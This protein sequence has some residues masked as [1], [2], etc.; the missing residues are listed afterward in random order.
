MDGPKEVMA[1]TT[2]WDFSTSD[3]IYKFCNVF[4]KRG[5]LS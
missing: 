1:G 5:W 4:K 2:G 3:F